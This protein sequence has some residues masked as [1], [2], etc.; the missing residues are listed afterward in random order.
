[1]ADTVDPLQFLKE[2]LTDSATE[3][4]AAGKIP[5]TPEGIIVAYGSI[6]VMALLPIYFGAKRSVETQRKQKVYFLV[7]C[8]RC[9]CSYSV[10]YGKLYTGSSN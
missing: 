6:V 3:P 7:W 10:P 9:I 2:N 1:M 5:A 8:T 4:S